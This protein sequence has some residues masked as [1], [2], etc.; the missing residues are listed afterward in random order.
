M[1]F[2]DV[3][4]Q[5]VLERAFFG[6]IFTLQSASEISEYDSSRITLT[7]CKRCDVGGER[8]LN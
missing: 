1:N 4:A 8:E 3:T 2:E 7:I 6:S 5:N